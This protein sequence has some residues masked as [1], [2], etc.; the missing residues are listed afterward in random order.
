MNLICRKSSFDAGHRV[1]NQKF[2]CFN[3]H[4]HTYLLELYYGFNDI[5]EIGYAVDFSEIKRLP[6]AWIQKMMDHGMILNPA[7]EDLIQ[8]CERNGFTKYIM[9]LDQEYCNPSAENIGA[10]I[11]LAAGYLLEDAKSGLYID[12][13]TLWETPNCKVEIGSVDPARAMNFY[14]QRQ[15]QLDEFKASKGKITYDDRE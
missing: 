15:T 10:E 12:H 8:L 9:S 11:L 14:E 1:M 2:K 7:D 5:A 13:I 4:G 6:E 3:L